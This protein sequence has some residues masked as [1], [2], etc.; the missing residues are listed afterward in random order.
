MPCCCARVAMLTYPLPYATV[1]STMAFR[2]YLP[3]VDS[4]MGTSPQFPPVYYDFLWLSI[5]SPACRVNNSHLFNRNYFLRLTTTLFLFLVLFHRQNMSFFTTP[6]LDWASRDKMH[7]VHICS[8]IC[9]Y[10][11][12]FAPA[13]SHFVLCR[14]NER[15]VEL[16]KP[17]P[18][19][20]KLKE[21]LQTRKLRSA[22]HAKKPP[23]KRAGRKSKGKSA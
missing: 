2:P 1:R 17:I 4:F 23:A 6:L 12:L 3:F 20:G 14:N 5:S 22:R 9:R 15:I 7:N 19:Y 8:Y 16:W 18:P 10:H 21:Y 13:N 11:Y